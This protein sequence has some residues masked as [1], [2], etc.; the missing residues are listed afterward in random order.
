MSAPMHLQGNVIKH[1][2]LM[3]ELSETV[4]KRSLL[5]VS[6]VSG[7]VVNS[8]ARLSTAAL[9]LPSC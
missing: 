5:E 2:N 9:I 4:S 1:V 6:E 7:V 8:A 3:S